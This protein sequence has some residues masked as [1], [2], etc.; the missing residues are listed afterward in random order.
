VTLLGTGAA[1]GWP[2][3]FCR[4]ASCEWA[5]SAGVVRAHA[6]ALVDDAVL[7]DCGPDVPT[8]AGRY[9][10]ALD[11]VALLLLTHAHVDHA[12]PEAM[13][14]R[15]WARCSS[16]LV[17]AGPPEAVARYEHWIEPGGPVTLRA[18]TAGDAVT[19]GAYTAVALPANH[20][21][22][23]TGECVLWDVTAPT[24]RLLYAADT[25][26]L[27]VVPE[28]P[29]DV[30]LLEET[31][32]DWRGHRGDHL[33]LTTFGEAVAALRRSGAVREGTRVVATHLG[34]TNPPLP[35]LARRL[36][37]YGA[38]VHPDG[39]VLSG[40]AVA[41]E[42]A[43]RVL[44]LGGARS[45]K[46]V[47]AERRLLAEPSVVYAATAVVRDD[48]EWGERV[49]LHRAR[50]PAHWQTVE[51][52]DLVALLAEEGPPLLV[53]CLTLWLSGGG[54]A[55]SLVRAWRRARRRVVAVSNEVGSGVVP[56]TASGRSFRDA[57]GRLNAAIAAESDEVWLVTAGIPARLR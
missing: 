24:G 9:G 50:R 39:T 40:P 3:A 14:W 29:Y 35:E 49:A 20:G 8:S 16:P 48:P 34:D 52:P 6:S 26:P 11:R 18:V 13:L 36:A 25:G 45:G 17:V 33:D 47:E 30:V 42:Q 12:A 22:A 2:S 19:V 53:D 46:S 43:R 32:G 28:G 5:R 23:L 54:D 4:C 57:L 7:L 15:S 38:E 1:A 56:A 44:V 55:E 27:R 31:F 21:D 37:L 51:E 41:P 10:V